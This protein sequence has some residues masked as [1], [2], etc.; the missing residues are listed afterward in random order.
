M[1]RAKTKAAELARE[2]KAR[3]ALKEKKDDCTS[4]GFEPNSADHAKCVMEMT[5]AERK[6]EKERIDSEEIKQTQRR[7]AE[8][9]EDQA[10]AARE[11]AEAQKELADKQPDT[12]DRLAD[13]YL[14]RALFPNR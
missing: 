6:L 11:A 5:I 13:E 8:A 1:E 3:L 7:M 14:K 10:R 2:E 12:M 9:A 4:F